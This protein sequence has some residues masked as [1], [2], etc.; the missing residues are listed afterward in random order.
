MPVRKNTVLTILVLSQLIAGGTYLVVKLGLREFDPFSLGLLR[1]LIAGTV[2]ALLLGS[3]KDF[4]W[5]QKRDLGRFLVLA[6]LAVPLNQGLFLYG[7]KY[8][9]ASHGALLYAT[10][11]L[12]VLCLSSVILGERP[13]ALKVAGILLGF[14]GVIL[15]LFDRGLAFA[16]HTIAG[17]LFVLGGVITWSLY[18]IY[19]KKLLS[20]YRPLEVTGFS[21]ALGS[22][23]FLPV[24][25][26]FL[27]RMDFG[28]VGRAGLFS[29]FYLAIM[30]SVIAYLIW[31]WALSNLEASK[32]AV[33]SN[34]QPVI[35]AAL[36]WVL[37]KEPVTARFVI[38][39]TVVL[40]GVIM[41]ERG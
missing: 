26:P 4:R 1:F 3:R 31:S 38:G 17:D 36:A 22:L 24:G 12:Q 5:F 9:V 10:T 40:A 13:T 6:L 33:I 39:T 32:V 34:L 29:L 19:S 30:T 20:R 8:T 21:L 16:R 2:F 35:A 15:V 7:M 28:Q 23:L 37:F 18:T 25:L 27:A 14:C 41:A 11:P